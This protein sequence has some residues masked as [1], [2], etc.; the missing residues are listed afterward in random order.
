MAPAYGRAPTGPSASPTPA[1]RG[2]RSGYIVPVLRRLPFPS[3]TERTIRVLRKVL[4]TAVGVQLALAIGMSVV[5]SY[6]R[7]GKKPK[8]F[9]VTP[10]RTV[11]VGDGTITTYTFGRD[12]Y[13]AMLTAIEGA[14]RQIL[15]ET[16]IWK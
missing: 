10:P 13:A 8:P 4:M 1:V 7:R 11:P 5:D 15:L 6:R 3:A 12:L 2:R 14:Q 9:P 16:Y